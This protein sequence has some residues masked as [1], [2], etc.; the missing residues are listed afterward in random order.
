MRYVFAMASALLCLLILKEA[1]AG[2]TW[3]FECDAWGNCRQVPLCDSAFDIPPPAPAAVA[4]IPPPAV[5]PILTPGIPPP[6]TTSCRQAYI[7]DSWGNC[8]FQIVCQ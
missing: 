1:E 6:G 5:A 3:E 4:P 7:C 8:D 2:C